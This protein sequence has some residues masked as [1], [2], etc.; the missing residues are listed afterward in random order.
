[1]P[2]C[3]EHDAIYR[4]VPQ[5]YTEIAYNQENRP[6]VYK[7]KEVYNINIHVTLGKSFLMEG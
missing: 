1:M 6:Q 3:T 4:R 7:N 2:N 5:T